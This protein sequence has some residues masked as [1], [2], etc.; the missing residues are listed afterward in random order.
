MK[1]KT[2]QLL[3]AVFFM[4]S[5]TSCNQNQN[6]NKENS[7]EKLSGSISVSGAFAL[8]PMVVMW[9]Q[10]FQKIHPEVQINVSAGGAGKGM[11]DVL[12]NMVELAMVSR[13]IKDEEIQQGA[14]FVAV[15]KDAVLPTINASN[16]VLSGIQKKG[17]TKN[18]LTSIYLD[19]NPQSWGK[20]FGTNSNSK[21]NAFTRSD[22][23][24]AAEMWAKY[25]GKKQEDLLGTGVFGDPGIADAVK[26]DVN[27]IGYNNVI[28]AYDIKTRKLY[29]GLAIL[30]LDLNENGILEPEENFYASLDSVMSAI[31]SGKYPSP[32]ARDLFLVSKGKPTNPIVN[33]FIKWILTDGQT[34]VDLGGYVKLTD[35]KLKTEL[36]KL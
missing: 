20:L 33:E 28:F 21:V 31:Q 13:E 25:L 8:Y 3:L 1:N 35:D 30:P 23:C 18:T 11:T 14:W 24:G 6:V 27:G 16:P 4:I 17:I 5:A 34:F 15:T 2:F 26:N 7:T 22:A 12:Q 9:A 32:P 10:E 36:S 19:K 29:P